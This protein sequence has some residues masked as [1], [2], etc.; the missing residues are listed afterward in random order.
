MPWGKPSDCVTS[1][2]G[3]LCLTSFISATNNGRSWQEMST[4]Q[5]HI[6]MVLQ[7][8]LVC[9]WSVSS[10]TLTYVSCRKQRQTWLTTLCR[11]ACTT[12]M[13][14]INHA[15]SPPSASCR[16]LACREKWRMHEWWCLRLIYYPRLPL[17]WSRPFAVKQYISC[18][19]GSQPFCPMHHVR[20]SF[21]LF[22]IV[23]RRR[24]IF[25]NM[26]HH[27]LK[28]HIICD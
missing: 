18:C 3:R 12:Q 19:S 22:K 23:L 1:Q 11:W 7:H 13:D 16:K 25:N 2:P 9:D 24:C 15:M 21:S 26:G 20:I 28:H 10:Y 5:W 17:H 27:A 14:D 8:E 4:L 6:S